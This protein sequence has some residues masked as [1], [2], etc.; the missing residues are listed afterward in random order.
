MKAKRRVYGHFNR[1]LE[2]KTQCVKEVWG[3]ER[4][5]SFT[6][7]QCQFKRGYGTDSLYCKKHKDTD[8]KDDYYDRMKTAGTPSPMF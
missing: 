4:S 6:S 7:W 2:N 5:S 3:N 1:S 8:A